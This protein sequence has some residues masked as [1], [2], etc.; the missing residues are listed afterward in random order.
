VLQHITFKYYVGEQEFT[1]FGH[2]YKWGFEILAS[3]FNTSRTGFVPGRRIFS[4]V[5]LKITA[6]GKNAVIILF[7][8]LL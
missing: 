4:S 5:V 7:I 8:A 6:A 1:F 2:T 3:A